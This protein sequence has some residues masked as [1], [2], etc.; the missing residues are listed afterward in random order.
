LR[1]TRV[2]PPRSVTALRAQTWHYGLVARYWDEF[3]SSG[4]EIAYFQG[5]IERHGEPALD[6]GCGA[7]RLLLPYLRAGLD[8]DGCDVSPDM[9]ALCRQ[10][11][12]AEGLSPNL[13]AQALHE[14]DLPRAY[15][16]IVVCGAFGLGASRAQDLQALGR[17]YDHLEPGGALALDNEVPYANGRQW[18]HWRKDRRREL[19]QAW[20]PPGE[21]ARARNGDEYGLRS[22]L[23]ELDPLE[24]RATLEMHAELWRDG[25][26]VAEEERALTMNFYFVHEL[27]LLLERVGYAD[28]VV[29]GG[30]DDG[31]PTPDHDFLVFLATK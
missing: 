18:A 13:Y 11:A 12:E 6:A 28:V 14:L 16:T 8:V 4:P 7:G 10:R 21:H 1:T 25:L 2:G 31:E 3:N 30:Y 24:Q 26:V 19:P 20:G 5:V 29:R 22:R 9:L 15:R 27:V 17:L 23:V